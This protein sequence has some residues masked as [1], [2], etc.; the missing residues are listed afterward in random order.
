MITEG[1]EYPNPVLLGQV[2]A[3]KEMLG[4][5]FYDLISE[6]FIKWPTGFKFSLKE[7]DCEEIKKKVEKLVLQGLANKRDFEQVSPPIVINE[8]CFL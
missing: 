1:E 2:E 8:L 4:Q 6:G 3:D 5:Q 7:L